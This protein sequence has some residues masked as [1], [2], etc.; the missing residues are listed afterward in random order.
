MAMISQAKLPSDEHHW[1]LVIISQHC[2][3]ATSHYL[4]QCWHRSLPLYGVTRPQWVKVMISPEPMPYICKMDAILFRFQCIS[5]SGISLITLRLRQNGRHFAD[6]LFKY[7]FLNENAWIS[8]KIS[9]KCIPK[10]PI[11]NTSDAPCWNTGV[12]KWR[13]K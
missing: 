7:I 8:I 10:D 2:R 6:D 3:Q 5:A 12:W 11:N 9:L 4:N 1:T 13:G